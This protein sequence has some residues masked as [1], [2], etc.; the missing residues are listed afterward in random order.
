MEGA[1]CPFEVERSEATNFGEERLVESRA[2]GRGFITEM[3]H[4]WEA[5]AEPAR[6]AGVRVLHPL[7]GPSLARGGGVSVAPQPPFSWG[8]GGPPGNGPARG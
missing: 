5:A 3:A 2:P 4:A 1:Q 6:A 7:L 8:P